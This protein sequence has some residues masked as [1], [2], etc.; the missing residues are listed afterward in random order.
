MLWH[1]PVLFLKVN[2]QLPMRPPSFLV[3]TIVAERGRLPEPYPALVGH[4]LVY[5]AGSP[6]LACAVL[7]PGC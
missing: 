5:F 2:N 7:S 3:I 6:M 1:R 4:W